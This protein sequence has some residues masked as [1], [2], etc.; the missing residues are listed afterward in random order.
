M[1]RR[2]LVVAERLGQLCTVG[3]G[4]VAGVRLGWNEAGTEAA[5]EHAVRRNVG[6]VARGQ[7]QL[8]TVRVHVVAGPV[9][10]GN[11]SVHRT[12]F[13]HTGD[14]GQGASDAAGAGPASQLH[15]AVLAPVDAPAVLEQP[16]VCAVLRSVADHRHRVGQRDGFEAAAAW[17]AVEDAAAAIQVKGGEVGIDGG[18]HGA[19]VVD[20]GAKQGLGAAKR[21]VGGVE[22]GALVVGR[23]VGRTF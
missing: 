2:V 7:R 3:V 18:E 6:D 16:V 23:H 11:R 10:V 17:A 20:Q 14:N 5:G 4:I 8:G 12:Q 21:V 13:R 15:V 19:V 22:F 1:L 9:Q